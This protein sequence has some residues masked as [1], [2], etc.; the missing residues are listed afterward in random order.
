MNVNS[1]TYESKW[2]IEK[3]FMGLIVFIKGGPSLISFSFNG[4]CFPNISER[5][6]WYT[7]TCMLGTALCTIETSYIV[8]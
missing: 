4:S 8:I 7:D 3:M 2:Q 5:V 6:L 1:E